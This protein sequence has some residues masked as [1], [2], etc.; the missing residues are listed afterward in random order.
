M[1]AAGSAFRLKSAPE[2]AAARGE[3]LPPGPAIGRVFGHGLHGHLEL[4][5]GVDRDGRSVLRSQS[6][7][8]PFHLSK[9]HHD[10]GVLVL[11]VVSP[12]AGLFAGDRVC[13]R[14]QVEAGA[15]LLL[16]TPSAQ[17]VH[18][19]PEGFASMTQELRVAAGA[20]LECWPELLILHGGACYRQSTNLKVEQGG[21]VLFFESLAPGR[22][23]AGEAFAF[24]EYRSATNLSVGS[25]LLVRERF[26]LRPETEAVAAL[27]ARFPTAYYASCIVASPRL[28][29]ESACWAAIHALQNSEALV[30]CSSLGHGAW[31]IKCVAAGSVALRRALQ[32]IRVALYE[33]LDRPVPLLRRNGWT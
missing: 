9:P 3:R 32:A 15:K 5:C 28:N 17:R 33:A 31:A 10:A 26:S 25:E 29:A 12:T 23:A 30:G 6:F 18:R 11:N 2:V 13:A 1:A 21:E 4:V 8:A 7:C 24:T 19:M 22:V 27:R 14:V 16:T 20:S